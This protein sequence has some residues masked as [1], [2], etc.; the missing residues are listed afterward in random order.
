MGGTKICDKFCSITI[1]LR[2]F[3]R[4]W[5][6]TRIKFVPRLFQ[7]LKHGLIRARRERVSFFW[8]ACQLSV[9]IDCRWQQ[10]NPIELWGKDLQ[11]SHS[12]DMET[13]ADANRWTKS[14]SVV[15][16]V[17]VVVVLIS[18]IGF[19]VTSMSDYPD[20]PWYRWTTAT[21]PAPSI[22][23]PCST[24]GAMNRFPFLSI[25]SDCCYYSLIFYLA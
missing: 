5:Y 11:C 14:L 3:D 1:K 17:V 23:L 6:N 7:S 22:S 8:R 12:H 10:Q 19:F 16:V 21:T 18:S 4:N 2:I 13:Y 20:P 24:D 15:C 9:L 25:Y